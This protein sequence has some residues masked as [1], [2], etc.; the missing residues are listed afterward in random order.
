MTSIAETLSLAVSNHKAG[1]LKEAEVLYKQVLTQNPQNANA[2]HL[3]GVLSAQ[4]GRPE[5]SIGYIRRAIEIRDDQAAF[6]YNLANALRKTGELES[7]AEA[8]QRGLELEPEHAQSW[9]DLAAVLRELGRTEE[10]IAA[11]QK[12]LALRPK[13]AEACNNI[14]MLLFDAG[15]AKRGVTFI[16]RA[17]EIRPDFGKAHANLGKVSLDLGHANVAEMHLRRA[18]TLLP[19]DPIV[20]N[21]L[22]N[23]LSLQAKSGEAIEHYRRAL[24]IDPEYAACYVNLANTYRTARRHEDA[25]QHYANALALD[26]SIAQA[27]YGRAAILERLSDLEGAIESLDRALEIEPDMS[28]AVLLKGRLLRRSEHYDD[29]RA[30]LSAAIENPAMKRV[31]G[32]LQVELG[33]VLDR[34]GRYDDAF[35][36]FS[37]GQQLLSERPAAQH[38]DWT[39]YLSTISRSQKWIEEGGPTEW[40]TSWDDG[41]QVP[42]FFVGFPRSGTTLTEQILD[43]HPNLVATDEAPLISNLMQRVPDLLGERP[44]FPEGVGQLQREH[45]LQLRREYMDEAAQFVGAD[46][47]QEC[48]LV[49]KLPLNLVN[50]PIIRRIFPESR[51]ICALRDPRDVCL[52]C[53][54]QEFR[55]NIAM[56]HFYSIETT[57]RLYANVMNLWLH[58]RTKLGMPA[59]ESR[60]EDLVADYEASARRLLEFLGEPWDDAVLEYTNRAREKVVSTPSY[61]AVSQPIYTS[62]TKRWERYEKHITK[63]QPLLQPFI[64][65]FG[66]ES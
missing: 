66:Y 23:A 41:I 20:N 14:G 55:P 35:G 4:S 46:A 65:E 56:V 15:Q 32:S 19:D 50:L 38:F 52:S 53:L 42:V 39:R 33:H 8:Y 28:G 51:L 30:Y 40:E 27:H 59:I 43:S 21:N 37:S 17:V 24:E 18:I 64:E 54:M 57:A 63:V 36:A 9:F 16:Q 2:L 3:L 6:H 12:D 60:Y 44:P 34:M 45:V 10:A 5:D 7:A 58:Y 29:A 26:D 48:R 31:A 1:N 11:Y 22:G 62:S 61:A 47:L 25:L 13:H 49:D